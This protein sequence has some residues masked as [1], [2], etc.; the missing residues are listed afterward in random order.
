MNHIVRQAL[1]DEKKKIAKAIANSYKEELSVL[2]KHQESLIEVFEYGIHTERFWIWLEGYQVLGIAA[3][4]DNSG[5]AFTPDRKKCIKNFGL[6]RGLIASFIF[7]SEFAKTLP[8][9]KTTGYIEFVGVLDSARGR[10]ISKKI[11]LEIIKQSGQYDEFLLD[12]MDNNSAALKTYEKL[13]FREY[14]REPFRGGKNKGIKE[15]VYMK[16]SKK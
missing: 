2:S 5:R 4:S 11:L 3:C 8:Y 9:P 13:G 14:K 7:N 12:V 10:G 6:I 15:R 1:P 16:L